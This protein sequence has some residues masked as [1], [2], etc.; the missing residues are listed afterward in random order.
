MNDLADSTGTLWFEES[1][2]LQHVRDGREELFDVCGKL[3][4]L[5]KVI[6]HT[7]GLAAPICRRLR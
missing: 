3:Q 1:V 5:S 2:G 7:S 6:R 4:R